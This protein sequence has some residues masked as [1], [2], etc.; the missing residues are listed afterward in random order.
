MNRGTDC[1]YAGVPLALYWSLTHEGCLD[2]TFISGISCL[3]SAGDLLTE[4]EAESFV[5]ASDNACHL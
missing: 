3:L 4:G 5:P 1:C 2:V